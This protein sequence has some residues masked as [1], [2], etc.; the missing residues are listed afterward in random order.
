MPELIIPPHDLLRRLFTKDT[1]QII[2]VCTDEDHAADPYLLP[3]AM[4]AR[5]QSLID[6]D[7]PTI[8]VC[9]KGLKLSQGAAAHLRAQGHEAWALEGGLQTWRR[10]RFPTLTAHS[11]PKSGLWVTAEG[12]EAHAINY[13]ADRALPPDHHLLEVHTDQVDAVADRF[14]AQAISSATAFLDHL[15][16]SGPLR[17]TPDIS[18]AQ[19]GLLAYATREE[20][21]G[22]FDAALR[23]AAMKGE[24]Q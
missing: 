21:F 8:I 11:L 9:Q 17:H 4:R 10:R 3:K 13:I 5:A 12:P 22:I 14:N 2:D 19:M 18:D 15:D 20:A 23:A 16:L 24:A 7:G 6:V 1:P